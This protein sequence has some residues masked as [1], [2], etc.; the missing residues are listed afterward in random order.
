MRVEERDD[1]SLYYSLVLEEAHSRAVAGGRLLD[2]YDSDPDRLMDFLAARDW[3]PLEDG[4][5]GLTAPLTV[6]GAE[7][8]LEGTIH[9][10]GADRLLKTRFYQAVLRGPGASLV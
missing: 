6:E 7:A 8:T 4:R 1:R 10:L 9:L 2:L 3:Q 5:A